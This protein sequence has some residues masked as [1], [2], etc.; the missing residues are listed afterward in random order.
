M[1]RFAEVYAAMLLS[2]LIGG[3]SFSGSNSSASVHYN[4]AG[5]SS[6]ASYDDSSSWAS[7][8][9]ELSGFNGHE[10]GARICLD[11]EMTR[12]CEG[13]AVTDE[14]GSASIRVSGA[15]ADV[16][17][18]AG[19]PVTA[20]LSDGTVLRGLAKGNDAVEKT[21]VLSPS[22]SPVYDRASKT[23]QSVDEALSGAAFSLGCG[24]DDLLH[25]E[26]GSAVNVMLKASLDAGEPLDENLLVNRSGDVSIVESRLSAGETPV[27]I[28]E[29]YRLGGRF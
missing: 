17:R 7:I 10:S 24:T 8:G 19:I 6:E 25:A 9:F 2:A 3:C 4:D 20:V 28:A 12:V 23:G 22:I 26:P 18:T 1:R 21:I 16:I 5:Y 29:S 14:N 15:E 27:E 13:G 11:R